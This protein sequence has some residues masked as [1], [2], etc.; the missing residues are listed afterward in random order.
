MNNAAPELAPLAPPACTSNGTRYQRSMPTSTLIASISVLL[1][2]ALLG[3]V[4]SLC[5]AGWV[6]L[7]YGPMTSWLVLRSATPPGRL[8]LIPGLSGKC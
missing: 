1:A 8:T 3:A 5:R 4:G 2:A 7:G 6:C